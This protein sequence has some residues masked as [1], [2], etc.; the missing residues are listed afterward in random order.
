MTYLHTKWRKDLTR[1]IR[2]YTDFDDHDPAIRGTGSTIE[3]SECNLRC[4]RNRFMSIRD[5]CRAILEIGVYRNLERSTAE[6]Y[7]S[8]KLPETIYVGIDIDDKSFLDS[9][10]KNIFTIKNDSSNYLENLEKIKSFGVEQFDFIF[11]D[12]WHSINQMIKDWEYTN[13]L[14]DYGIVG[15]HDT[16]GHPGP[17]FFVDALDTNKWIVEKL[18]TGDEGP[19][20]GISF[21]TKR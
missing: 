20:W 18:C 3:L 11:I 10:E 13:L 6:I 21:A 4:I 17:M 5:N 8:N 16:N 1:E 19:D 2:T 14:S 15:I 7:F 9:K 12:G